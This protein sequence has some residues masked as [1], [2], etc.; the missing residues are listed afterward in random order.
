MHARDEDAFLQ[1]LYYLGEFTAL[2]IA[3]TLWKNRGS[4]PHQWFAIHA[5]TGRRMIILIKDKECLDSTLPL[6]YYGYHTI[7]HKDSNSTFEVDT[8][9]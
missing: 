1:S 7:S 5:D 2:T 9:F 4:V 6:E 3:Q 8:K